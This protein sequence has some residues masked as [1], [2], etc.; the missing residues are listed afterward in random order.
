MFNSFAPCF[1]YSFCIPPF[2]VNFLTDEISLHYNSIISFYYIIQTLGVC[3]IFYAM[4]GFTTTWIVTQKVCD[5][6]EK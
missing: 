4:Y 6:S 5:A 1:F 3:M 2:P